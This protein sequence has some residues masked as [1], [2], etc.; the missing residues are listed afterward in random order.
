MG[1]IKYLIL[2]Q[3]SKNLLVE[4][5]AASNIGVGPSNI[6]THVYSAAL[7]FLVIL[8]LGFIGKCFN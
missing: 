5:V 2:F 3:L 4:F 1:E 6:R 7:N 8:S